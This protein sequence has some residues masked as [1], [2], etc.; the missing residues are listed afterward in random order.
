MTDR[1]AGLRFNF[2]VPEALVGDWSAWL[3]PAS[4][5]RLAADVEAAGFDAISVT[6]HPYP[7]TDW[8]AGGGHHALDP[9]VALSFM[10]AG[11]T[12]IRLMTNVLVLPYRHPVVTAK[13]IATL[14]VLCGGRLIVGTAIGYLRPEFDAVGADFDGRAATFERTIAEMRAAWATATQDHPGHVMLPPPAQRPHPPIWIGG[15]SGAARR[16]AVAIGDGWMP[17][18]QNE[19]SAQVTGTPALTTVDDLA[20]QI[21]QLDD[22]RMAAGRS[23]RLDVCFGPGRRSAVNR[24]DASE[25]E[26]EDELA[27]YKDAGVTWLTVPSKAKTPDD[28]GREMERW[29]PVIGRRVTR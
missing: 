11:T 17:F 19:Q 24:G 28:V 5:G 21:A 23:T 7:P 22:A 4:L 20:A 15:N 12:T 25:A 16:R 18:G 13:A 6:D 26:L 1:P 27:S 9:F 2:N 29:A 14:D 8:L 3:A 10:A